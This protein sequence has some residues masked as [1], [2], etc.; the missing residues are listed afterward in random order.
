[1]F[2]ELLSLFLMLHEKASSLQNFNPDIYK[3]PISD[4]IDKLY[5]LT[6]PDEQKEEKDKFKRNI[7]NAFEYYEAQIKSIIN[8][9]DEMTRNLSYFASNAKDLEEGMYNMLNILNTRIDNIETIVDKIANQKK[10]FGVI[11]VN[12]GGSNIPRPNGDKTNQA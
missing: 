4:S 2:H 3:V 10:T 7:K 1:M 6:D 9:I 5:R 8:I 11:E 12:R